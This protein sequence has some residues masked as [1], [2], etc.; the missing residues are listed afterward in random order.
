MTTSTLW[1]PPVQDT[2]WHKWVGG[3][4]RITVGIVDDEVLVRT[5]IRG[6]LERAGEI[7]VVG[8][9]CDGSGAVDLAMAHRPRVLLIDAA[10]AG[11]NEPATVRAVRR[12]APSTQVVLLAAPVHSGLLL[13]VLRAGAAG[14]LLKDSEP[15]ELVN[16][17]RV[18]AGGGTFLC[19]AATRTLIGHVV[20]GH[21]ERR[22][23]A[24]RR[25]GVLTPREREVLTCVGKGMGNARIA[26][27]L[28]LSE[29]SVKAYMSRLLTKLRCDNRVQAAL[30]AYEA[31]LD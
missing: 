30:I 19:P 4:N 20:D 14:F 13:P 21:T 29:G 1:G 9:A 11:L 24:R 8:E 2:I 15:G 28:S 25:V 16:A 3:H 22:E 31:N 5:G 6:V 23:E 17:V 12:Q 18:V 10:M 26:R 27:L 7:M